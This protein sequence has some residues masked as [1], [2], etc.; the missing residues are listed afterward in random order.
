MTPLSS[1]ILR[2]YDLVQIQ[3]NK[4]ELLIQV[5]SGSMLQHTPAAERLALPEPT[6]PRQH[7]QHQTDIRLI[8]AEHFQP[9]SP[10]PVDFN[11]TLFD[12]DS[13]SDTVSPTTDRLEGFR[14]P[15]PAPMFEFEELDFEET[16]LDLSLFGERRGSSASSLRINPF[17]CYASSQEH[18]KFLERVKFGR[19]C[20][21]MY[22]PILPIIIIMG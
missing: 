20:D 21:V 19:Y 14:L 3:N 10:A 15:T 13:D 8:T 4:I 1:D 9:P 18:T 6:T 17:K 22:Y 11:F 16:T 2:I 12:S 5:A 7:H